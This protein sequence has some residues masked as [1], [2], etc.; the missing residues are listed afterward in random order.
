MDTNNE[1]EQAGFGSSGAGFKQDAEDLGGKGAHTESSENR[2]PPDLPSSSSKSRGPLFWFGVVAVAGLMVALI[3]GGLYWL[4]QPT[5]E[6]EA[7]L[8]SSDKYAQA[9]VKVDTIPQHETAADDPT[10]SVPTSGD[11]V[12]EL[13]AS[14]PGSGTGDTIAVE[15]MSTL[16]AGKFDGSDQRS[17]EQRLKATS[18]SPLKTRPE[19]TQT[20]HLR[21]NN[22]D[23][24]LRSNRSQS[25]HTVD[26]SEAALT[27][28]FQPKLI[29]PPQSAGKPLYVV[30]V[31]S[32]PSK[33]DADEWLH[34]LRARNVQGGYITEQKIKGESW[35]RVRFGEFTS[36][37]EAE[38]AAMQLGF[39]E[40]WIARIR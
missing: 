35:F 17:K 27:S 13:N 23:E 3:G 15:P 39:R 25:Q 38:S 26:N 7:F 32:S 30:Q 11:G 1:W 21:K 14:A 18:T 37:D 31:F 9:V 10:Q 22:R 6:Q 33:D 5:V 34:S 20:S 12:S 24:M 19:V 40:P 2:T 29:P 16:Q 28:N 36:R 4:F 8:D